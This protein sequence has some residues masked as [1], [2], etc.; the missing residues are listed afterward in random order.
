MEHNQ[1]EF[2][3]GDV[4]VL[5]ESHPNSSKVKIVSLS[6]NKMFAI[7]HQD[8]LTV[9]DA[10]ETMTNRLTP[11]KEIQEIDQKAKELR[12]Q[13]GDNAKYVVL[14]IMDEIKKFEY[15]HPILLQERLSFWRLVKEKL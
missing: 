4:V 7:V 11:V 9:E 1:Y 8:E 2:K 13:F 12:S 6:P 14:E 5:D 10:W 15:G 3:P